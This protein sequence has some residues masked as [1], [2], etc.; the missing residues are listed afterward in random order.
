M[1]CLSVFDHFV[2]LTL[3]GLKPYLVYFLWIM[4]LYKNNSYENS[5][6]KQGVFIFNHMRQWNLSLTALFWNFP[7][8][9]CNFPLLFSHSKNIWMATLITVVITYQLL[10]TILVIITKSHKIIVAYSL[11]DI[12]SSYNK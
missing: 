6:C 3:K 7:L 1:N 9:I 11:T 2:G 10:I 4:A 5:S 12:T 8:M